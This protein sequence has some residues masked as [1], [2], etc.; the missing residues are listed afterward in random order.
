MNQYHAHTTFTAED[1]KDADLEG[2]C[3]SGQTR[4]GNV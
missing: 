4:D 1:A 3:H 2:H